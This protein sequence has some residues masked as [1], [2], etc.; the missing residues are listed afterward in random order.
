MRFQ[1][2]LIWFIYFFKF[3]VTFPLE[4]GEF[5]TAAS[6][7]ATSRKHRANKHLFVEMLSLSG[8]LKSFICVFNKEVLIILSSGCWLLDWK[9]TVATQ[10]LNS[11]L[12]AH[13]PAFATFFPPM[14]WLTNLQSSHAGAKLDHETFGV[15]GPRSHMTSWTPLP[16]S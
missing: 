5:G 15:S 10:R 4:S 3:F 13:K 9:V 1:P 14:S 11:T 7:L 6:F 8:W 12:K 16:P 2:F